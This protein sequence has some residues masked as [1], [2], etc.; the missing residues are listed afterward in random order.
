MAFPGIDNLPVLQIH[1]VK[2]RG[3]KL[4]DIQPILIRTQRQAANESADR[5]LSS[6]LLF[7]QVDLADQA[8]IFMRNPSPSAVLVAD[9]SIRLVRHGQLLDDP[10]AFSVEEDD[11]IFVVNRCRSQRTRADPSYAF[12]FFANGKREKILDTD[13]Y[14]FLGCTVRTPPNDFL[15]RVNTTN[16]AVA[17]AVITTVVSVVERTTVPAGMPGPA[18][19]KPGVNPW[20]LAMANSGPNSNGSQFFITVAPFTSGNNTYAIFGR[21]VSGTNVVN[22]INKV[23]TDSN[24]KPLTNVFIQQ[25]SIRRVG[26]SALAFDINAHNLP[27]ATNL[28]LHIATAS[29]Q[30]SLAFNNRLYADN[31]VYSSTNLGL[32]SGGSVGI[33]TSA[34]FSNTVAQPNNQVQQFFRLAQIQ[35]A[36][37]TFAPKTVLSRTLT[38]ILS[39]GL[40]TITISFDGAGGG[41]YT[42][43]GAIPGTVTTYTWVQDPYRGQLW[44]IYYSGLNPMTL[45]LD[46]A[47]NTNGSFAGTVYS[48]STLNV[49]G[50][51]TLTGP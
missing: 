13:F 49:S 45:R 46:F 31:Q 25:V 32:W 3:V 41:T 40:G 7:L 44:P 2:H 4:G 34:Q 19:V 39:G 12:G 36:S 27:V 42:F 51:F 15:G 17:A 35:Y 14:N 1:G 10:A 50:S 8:G 6:H 21:V 28:P 26:S 37:S 11:G 5:E 47:S 29:N 18:I 43:T 33:E 16:D 48:T 20:V 24:D 38:L 9:H 22:A 30:V 23:V